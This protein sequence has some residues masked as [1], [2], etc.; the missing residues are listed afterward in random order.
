[1]KARLRGSSSTGAP[2]FWGGLRVIGSVFDALLH[3]VG[4]GLAFDGAVAV[5]AVA[6]VSVVED[7]FDG[8]G[9][10]PGAAVEPAL[11]GPEAVAEPELVF[12]VVEAEPVCELG[13]EPALV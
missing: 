2:R 1:M 7:A 6:L 4:P 3:V 10:E 9:L 13:F 12:D 11:T 8:V 5:A